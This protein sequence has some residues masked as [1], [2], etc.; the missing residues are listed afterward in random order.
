MSVV[1][2][3]ASES[4]ALPQLITKKARQEQ[5]GHCK[6]SYKKCESAYFAFI[7]S[8]NALIVMAAK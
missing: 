4:P 2:S 6:T 7:F 8:S 5:A 3:K 1:R